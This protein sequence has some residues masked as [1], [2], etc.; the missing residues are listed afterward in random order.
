[1]LCVMVTVILCVTI[2]I[3]NYVVSH[4][5]VSKKL[6]CMKY[7]EMDSVRGF[8]YYLIIWITV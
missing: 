4:N 5:R 3:G 7:V 8:R 1:V 6:D 2:R